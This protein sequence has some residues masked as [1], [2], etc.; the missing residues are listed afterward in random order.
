MP[1]LEIQLGSDTLLLRFVGRIDFVFGRLPKADIQLRDMK[2]SRL[3]TQVFIDS[4]GSAFV[5]DLGSSG[6]TGYNNKKLPKGVIAPLVDGVKV[7]VGEV[8]IVYY[9]SEP[10]VNAIDPPGISEPRGLIRTNERPRM[11]ED[12]AT[13][14][15]MDKVSKETVGGPAEAPPT[16]NLKDFTEDGN[17]AAL[18]RKQPVS[19]PAPKKRRDTGIVEAPWEKDGSGMKVDPSK[20]V[21]GTVKQP[22]MPIDGVNLLA[23]TASAK[24]AIPSQAPLPPPTA[25]SPPPLRKE[26]PARSSGIPTVS[27]GEATHSKPENPDDDSEQLTDTQISNYLGGGNSGDFDNIDFGASNISTKSKPDSDK[28][29]ILFGAGDR[30]D[31][32]GSSLDLSLG[33]EDIPAYDDAGAALPTNDR[34]ATDER[35]FKPRKTRKLMKPRTG[36]ITDKTATALPT[37][38]ETEAIPMPAANTL[39]IPKPPGMLRPN[40]G[41]VEKVTGKPMAFA[42]NREP[43]EKIDDMGTGPGGD[44]VALNMGM[45]ADMRRQLEEVENLENSETIRTSPDD[46]D[47]DD[48]IEDLD[49]TDISGSSEHHQGDFQEEMGDMPDENQISESSAQD[50]ITD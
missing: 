32:H 31:D 7:R 42:E 33:D 11:F 26:G 4:H 38:A 47:I 3:H 13:V 18:S 20:I 10:P 41:T 46:D 17:A 9:D 12:S 49:I 21:G 44:T 27:L 35:A 15:A 2:V 30:L 8:R 39:F 25:F 14:M 29:E 24:P 43:A 37:G 23:P 16:V 40:D 45:L 5:R 28:D 34:G 1:Y 19:P 50:T 22:E 6:G 36:K 48:S